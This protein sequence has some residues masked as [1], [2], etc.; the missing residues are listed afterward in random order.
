M[1]ESQRLTVTENP[2]EEKRENLNEKKKVLEYLYDKTF[3]E[4]VSYKITHTQQANRTNKHQESW[5]TINE[6]TGRKT[7]KEVF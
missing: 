6:I 4:E 1:F 2:A 3:A 5:K 7:T